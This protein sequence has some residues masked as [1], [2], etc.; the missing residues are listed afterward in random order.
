MGVVVLSVVQ[1]EGFVVFVFVHWL[2]NLNSLSLTLPKM[3]GQT[4]LSLWRRLWFTHLLENGV[5]TPTYLIGQLGVPLKIEFLSCSED[6]C[7]VI[8]PSLF[9]HAVP[10]GLR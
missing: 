9:G 3:V 1:C 2:D 10:F 8:Y 6:V 7:G 4:V 5:T